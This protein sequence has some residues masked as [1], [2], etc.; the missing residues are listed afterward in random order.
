MLQVEG[1]LIWL[2]DQRTKKQGNKGTAEKWQTSKVLYTCRYTSGL[3]LI[4]SITI[5]ELGI[6]CPLVYPQALAPY[7]FAIFQLF[8]C[9]PAVLFFDP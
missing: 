1:I 2:L 4:Q 7:L 3:S 8:P 5:T 6:K 9:F